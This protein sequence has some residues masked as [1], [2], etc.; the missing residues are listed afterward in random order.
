MRPPI[1][2]TKRDLRQI[3]GFAALGRTQAEIA[4]ALGFSERT[5]RNKKAV[6]DEVFAAWTR[7]RLKGVTSVSAVSYRNA[8]DGDQRAV[9]FY[10][11]AFHGIS[12]KGADTLV[13]P[14]HPDLG[15]GSE[16]FTLADPHTELLR[17][18]DEIALR[19]AAGAQADAERDSEPIAREHNPPGDAPSTA[20]E[21][22]HAA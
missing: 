8:M 5:F 2:L 15:A 17:R 16:D 4:L 6:D 7:G 20:S 18:Y 3:E 11:G 21:E 14:D 10:L 13:N 12:I 19:Q 9:E 1:E 22:H